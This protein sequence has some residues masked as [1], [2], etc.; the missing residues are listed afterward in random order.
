MDRPFA[1]N[2]LA[3]A[4]GIATLEVI[5]TEKLVEAAAKRGASFGWR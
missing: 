5:E 2:D 3:M 4:A 1:K